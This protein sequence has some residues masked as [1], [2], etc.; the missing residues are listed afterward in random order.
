M[1]QTFL[2]SFLV[3]RHIKQSDEKSGKKSIL[4]N[5]ILFALVIAFAGF[6]IYTIISIVFATIQHVAIDSGKTDPKNM[7]LFL[8][9]VLLIF[10]ISLIKKPNLIF[11]TLALYI[12]SA[13]SFILYQKFILNDLNLVY[14]FVAP[15][16]PSLLYLLVKVITSKRISE[17]KDDKNDL[18]QSEYAVE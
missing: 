14:D 11:S 17:A 10:V 7:L 4:R 12:L 13:P 3:C 9:P 6:F 5:P 1:S 8:C 2:F 16:L 15:I 18:T